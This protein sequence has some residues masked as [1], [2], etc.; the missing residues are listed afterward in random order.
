[1]HCQS[2]RC[3]LRAIS[4]ARHVNRAF[5]EVDVHGV[6]QAAAEDRKLRPTRK[7][8]IPEEGD[9]LRGSETL[10]IQRSWTSASGQAV[11]SVHRL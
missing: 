2:C 11:F 5:A 1:M 4:L 9:T 3:D 10:D 7:M 6:D 8:D